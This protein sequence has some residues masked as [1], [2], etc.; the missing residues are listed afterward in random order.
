MRTIRIAHQLNTENS[1]DSLDQFLGDLGARRL[2]TYS[3]SV[4]LSPPEFGHVYVA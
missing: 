2:E 1:K 3:V 4:G